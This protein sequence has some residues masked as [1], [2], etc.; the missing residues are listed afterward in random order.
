[1]IVGAGIAGLLTALHLA[2]TPCHLITAGDFAPDIQGR[3]QDSDETPAP[4][5][6]HESQPACASSLAQGGIAAAIDPADS[7]G[8]HA[9]DTIRAGAGLTDPGVAH[10]VTAAAPNIIETLQRFGV[11]F[12][13]EPDGSLRLGLEG[14]HCA[15]RIIHAADHTGAEI[16]RA[17]AIAVAGAEHVTVWPQTRAHRL[18]VSNGTVRALAIERGGE[19]TQIATS[20]VVLATGGLG[21]LFTHTTNPL[22]ARGQ[23]IALAARAGA[24]LAD[25][26]FVQF[27]PTALALGTGQLPLISEAVRGEGVPLIDG[28]GNLI[29]DDALATRDIV[30]RAVWRASRSGREVFLDTPRYRRGINAV[31]GSGFSTRFP[32]IASRCRQAGIDPDSEPIP[33]RVAAHYSMGGVA[34]DERGRTSLRGLWAAG[35]VARTGLHGGNRLASNSLLEA[36]VYAQWIANDINRQAGASFRR[37]L[38]EPGGL[39]EPGELADDAWDVEVCD[40]AARDATP[41]TTLRKTPATTRHEAPTLAELREIISVALGVERDDATLAWAIEK[42]EPHAAASDEALVGLLMARAA[43]T[44]QNSVGA[45]WR[46]DDPNCAH[47]ERNVEH[48]EWS[49]S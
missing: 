14:G 37:E 49:A 48:L 12:D 34:V 16:M 11:Q 47:Q 31:G 6:Q 2:P 29:L 35:E 18:I 23:G 40:N 7:T 15:R 28:A 41:K 20:R 21:G 36:A 13:T 45:H 30:A 43:R 38:G 8:A 5:P 42:L 10:R 9:L 46:N 24:R 26:E 25:L 22:S 17:L 44:R 33:V 27:H 32:T 39:G 4:A 1:M 3:A 19:I